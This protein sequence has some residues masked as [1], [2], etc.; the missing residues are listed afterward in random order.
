MDILFLTQVLPFP[1]DAGPKVR[2]YYVLRHLAETGHRITLVSFVRASDRP[3]HVAHLRSHCSA[4]RTVRMRRSAWRDGLAL[5]SSLA[6][7]GPFL[8]ARD[9]S[10]AMARTVIAAARRMPVLFAV[11]SDQLSMA[12]YALLARRFSR[13]GARP[14]SVLDQHNAVFQ[15]PLRMALSEDRMW[16]R[17]LLRLEARRLADYERKT[18]ARFDHVVWVSAEDRRALYG[19]GGRAAAAPADQRVIPIASDPQAR[20]VRTWCPG[21]RRVTFMG[22]LHWPP[23]AQGMR[24]FLESIWP[25]VK[26]RAPAALLTVI[27]KEGREAI[28]ATV[29]PAVEVT[30][31]L[32]DPTP[33]L[34]ETAVFIVPLR[35]AGGMRVKILDAWSRGLPVVSTTLGAEGVCACHGQ[36]LLL[37]D[38]PVSFATA[39]AAVMNDA[40]LAGRLAEAGRRTV[41]QNYD[42]RTTYRLWD[43]IYPPI[44]GARGLECSMDRAAAI[45]RACGAR[46]DAAFGTGTPFP[47]EH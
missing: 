18:C 10:A 39:V 36:N 2:A 5:A 34:A 23:N 38:D 46:P 41:E 42:W 19:D 43:S 17:E 14:V 6:G 45:Q 20:A 29:D 47:S 8:A 33:Y 27:G 11:H 32:D 13:R 30:G 12:P 15:I 22:G 44:E 40:Q 4:V 25:L 1:L 28:G 37:A 21:A 24:W 35:A 7:G 26:V 9:W 31:F 3:E 16:R